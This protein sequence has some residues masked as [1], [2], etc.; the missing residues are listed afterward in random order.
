MNRSESFGGRL[1]R[2]ERQSRLALNVLF[3][4]VVFC[5]FI[6]NMAVVVGVVVAL[7]HLNV[8][9]VGTVRLDLYRFVL[10]IVLVSLILGALLSAF[11]SRVPMRPV[12]RV[13]NAINR[14]SAGDFKTRLRF[15]KW[16]R[17]HRAMKELSSSFN[18][19]AEELENTELLRTDFVNNFC[20]EFKTPI[21][22][23]AGFA[24]LLKRGNLTGAAAEYPD[25]IEEESLRCR[26]W[27]PMCSTCP[28]WKTKP[29]CA[30]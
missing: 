9:R 15:G 5:L 23:I 21:V 22:S 13:I 14:L 29:F 25:A 10:Y 11:V 26:L 3:A 28:R 7:I 27:P 2:E 4:A 12:Y 8:L 18:K 24:S 30:T 17:H 6:V 19:L 20:H 1:P 16:L